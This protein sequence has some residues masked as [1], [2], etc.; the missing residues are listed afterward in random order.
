MEP[1]EYYQICLQCLSPGRNS[2]WK[3]IEND[4]RGR[5]YHNLHHLKEMI[6]HLPA[7]SP[8]SKPD[9]RREALFGMALIYHDVVYRA[10]RKDNER[11]SADRAATDLLAAGDSRQ[12]ADYC[13]R[14]IMATKIH[15][16]AG[17]NGEDQK[18]LI[19]L[20][21]A[22]LARLPDE[23]DDYAAAVRKEFSLYPDFL[24]RPGRRKALQHFLDQEYIYHT[25]G[26]RDRFE[27]S[28]REN[29][30][31]ELNAL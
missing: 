14:L 5:A 3:E 11:R 2:A 23:Y 6:S 26:F 4:Y 1:S 31:R 29:L 27:A 16:P 13:R 22:V 9:G 12:E 7:N 25:S 10:G 18:L 30:R 24:Y 28:A 8:F 17:E 20:D 15:Q 19:D 21:L